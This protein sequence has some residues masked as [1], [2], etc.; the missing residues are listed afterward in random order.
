MRMAWLYSQIIQGA[1]LLCGFED[2]ELNG[3]FFLPKGKVSLDRV[4]KFL[5]EAELLDSFSSP[6]PPGAVDL[7]S[8][9][10][11]DLNPSTKAN[12]EGESSLV[13][14]NNAMFAWGRG[15]DDDGLDDDSVESE[16]ESESASIVVSETEAEE[17]TKRRRRR[18][19]RFMLRVPGRVGFKEGKLNLIVGPT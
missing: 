1:L 17:I 11:A 2:L 5:K 19:R 15:D 14:F 18:E 3:G 4:G 6:P 12:D 9:S 7:N 10:N 16:S 8:D 13:G